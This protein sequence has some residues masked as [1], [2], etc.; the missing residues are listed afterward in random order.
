M[1]NQRL[2]SSGGVLF[3]SAHG[4]LEVALISRGRVWCLPKGLIEIGETLEQAALREVKEET[5]LEGEPVKKIGEIT[6]Q[7]FRGRLYVKT[8]HF[9]LFRY[10]GG[11]ITAHDSEADKVSWFPISEAIRVLTYVNEKRRG[12]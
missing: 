7:F 2:V 3:R 4:D 6:Y 12:C 8:V 1:K 11:S 5:G 9:F 10:I